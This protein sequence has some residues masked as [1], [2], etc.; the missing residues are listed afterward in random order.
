MR[1]NDPDLS[2]QFIGLLSVDQ[3][4][5][6]LFRDERFYNILKKD[7]EIDKLLRLMD[8]ALTQPTKLEIVSGNNRI[9]EINTLLPKPFIVVVKDKKGDPIEGIR[10]SFRVISGAGELSNETPITDS[11]G[12]ART[13]FTLGPTPGTTLIE[14]H[15]DGVAEPV[16]FTA[17]AT[18][19]DIE[20]PTEVP[21]PPN[22]LSVFRLL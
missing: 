13:T 2:S 17:I 5:R 14:A 15:V 3:E 8:D 6:A 11:N 19:T 9:S 12:H 4:L 22:W 20:V 21:N 16:T 1:N 10:V 7:D 18:T